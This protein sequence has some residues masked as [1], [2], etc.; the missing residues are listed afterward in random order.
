MNDLPVKS[1]S[2]AIIMITVNVHD[3]L[4]QFHVSFDEMFRYN[5]QTNMTFGG[6]SGHY[7]S[8][9]APPPPSLTLPSCIFLLS[10]FTCGTYLLDRYHNENPECAPDYTPKVVF[11]Q[12]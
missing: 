7:P 10:I 6:S 12:T 1:C 11:G 8:P 3:L 5:M 2:F 4:N 9:S